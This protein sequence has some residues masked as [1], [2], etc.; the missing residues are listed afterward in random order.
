ME[1]AEQIFLIKKISMDFYSLNM[2]RAKQFL[3]NFFPMDFYSLN[4]EQAIFFINYYFSLWIF[5]NKI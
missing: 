5:A 3:Y 4:M 1:R 2:E